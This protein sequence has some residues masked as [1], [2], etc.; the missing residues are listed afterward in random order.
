MQ[1]TKQLREKK[2]RLF[3]I[4]LLAAV[5]VVVLGVP[6]GFLEYQSL[7]TGKTW[8][9]VWHKLMVRS[10]EPTPLDAPKGKKIDFLAARAIGDTFSAPPMISNIQAVDLDGDGLMDVLVCDARSNKVSW[11]RQYPAGVFTELVCAD[12]IL[13]PAHVRACDIDGDGDLDL[14][15][16]SMGT[17][18]PSNDKIGAIIILENDGHMHFRKHVIA[19]HIARV[20]DVRA[21]D[22]DGDGHLDLVATQF[23]Y[24]DGET[25]WLENTGGW[26]FKSHILQTI[27]GGINC[28]LCDIDHDGDLDIVTLISQEWEEIYLFINDGKGRFTPKLLWGSTNE[29]FGSSSIHMVDLDGDGDLDILYTNGDAFDYIPPR[30]RPWHGVNWLENK[31]NNE[32]EFHRIAN[33]GG[34]YSAQAVDIDHDGDLDIFVVSAFNLWDD[35]AAQSFIW[36]ENDGKMGFTK[37]D[38]AN[39]PTHLLCLEAADFNN[40][41]EVDMVTCGMH[42]YPPFD[43]MARVTLWQNNWRI[44][45]K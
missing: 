2:G 33:F 23:G 44:A 41:G 5:L 8:A 32:F 39:R 21:G 15:V 40:D 34:A 7:K 36:L 24:D 29:D 30:P 18:F 9:Q 14:L 20:S 12:S 37:H 4:V 6:L 35:P 19:D 28:E 17:I 42:A 26:Q 11:I 27:S 13:A 10:S 45:V 31:G 16:A 43:R 38:I 25:R 1:E 22:L 3:S